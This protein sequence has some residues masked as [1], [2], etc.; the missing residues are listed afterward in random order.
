MVLEAALSRV[1][2]ES[3]FNV[4]QSREHLQE[5]TYLLSPN[6]GGSGFNCPIIQL[7]ESKIASSTCRVT[8][9]HR[10]II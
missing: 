5:A 1:E 2:S 9:K 4:Q 8:S 6:V 10:D 7:Y 3:A